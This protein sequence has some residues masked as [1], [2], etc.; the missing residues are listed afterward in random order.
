MLKSPDHYTP[1]HNEVLEALSRIN[2]SP[3]E[4]RVLMATWRRTY[5]FRDK[6]TGKRKKFDQITL[7]E[8]EKLTGLDRRLCSRALL[9]LRT[10]GIINR[11]DSQNTGF[12]KS[13]MKSAGIISQVPR[14]S[15]P[16]GGLVKITTGMEPISSIIKRRRK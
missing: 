11:D 12:S 1:I 4:T 6:Q 8:F 9:G 2:L 10:K 13:F 14:I 7:G 3:Y 16:I 15:Q 5:G